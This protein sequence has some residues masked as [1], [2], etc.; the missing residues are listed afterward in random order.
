MKIKYFTR[1][2]LNIF[3]GVGITTNLH[4]LMD[5]VREDLSGSWLRSETPH[6]R[7]LFLNYFVKSFE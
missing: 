7:Y 2:G 3:R 6:S 5:I 4:Y 1:S